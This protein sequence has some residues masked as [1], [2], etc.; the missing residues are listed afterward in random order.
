LLPWKPDLRFIFAEITDPFAH[1]TKTWKTKL[2]SDSMDGGDG[3]EF[4]LK[5][6]LIDSWSAEIPSPSRLT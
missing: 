6:V 2:R 4:G 1:L 3:F 5:S